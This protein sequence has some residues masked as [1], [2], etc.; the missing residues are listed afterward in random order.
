MLLNAFIEIWILIALGKLISLSGILNREDGKKL[1]LL[2]I[3]VLLPFLTFRILYQTDLQGMLM[4]PILG[5]IALAALLALSMAA[6]KL[7]KL[8]PKIFGSFVLTST[9]PNTGYLGYPIM[10]ALFGEQGLAAAIVFNLSFSFFTPTAGNYVAACYGGTCPTK[11]GLL[12]EI[13]LYPLF[14]AFLAGALFNVFSVPI[15]A[16]LL[17]TVTKVG[18][19]TI[20]VVLIALGVLLR[21]ELPKHGKELALVGGFRFLAAPLI[22]FLLAFLVPL[23][24]LLR[25]ILILELAMPPAIA[26][27]ALAVDRQLDIDFTENTIFL[28]TVVSMIT[29][30][31]L[32]ALV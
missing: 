26:N 13:F 14:I 24:P 32:A 8:P 30:P 1:N 4:L 23:P 12:R 9:I 27:L 31:V 10:L 18:D 7:L 20:P 29:I 15:P 16:L 5:T 25:A 2:V 3:Y 28:L 6:G 11:K 21:L 19:L 22:G 17:S